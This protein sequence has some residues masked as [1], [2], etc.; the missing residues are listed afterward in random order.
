ML[1]QG[2]Q[3]PLTG[4]ALAIGPVGARRGGASLSSSRRGA[5]AIG[6]PLAKP[7]PVGRGAR[8]LLAL[9]ARLAHVVECF[10]IPACAFS[11]RIDRALRSIA[12]AGAVTS[13]LDLGRGRCAAPRFSG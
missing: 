4:N 1:A 7:V 10:G 12:A 9:R 3:I 5:A 13:L 11:S 6:F 2:S 8:L